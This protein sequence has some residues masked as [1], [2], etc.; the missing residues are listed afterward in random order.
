[1]KKLFY[2]C[3]LACSLALLSAVVIVGC[4]NDDNTTGVESLGGSIDTTYL[5]WGKQDPRTWLPKTQ[6]DR[7][8]TYKN[9]GF[10]YS[11]QQ[12][13]FGDLRIPKN[14]K[15]KTAAGYPLIIMVH[16]GAWRSNTTL[17]RVAPLIEALTDEGMATWSIEFS[18]LGNTG[19]GYPGTFRDVGEGV[20][21]VRTL[22]PEWN[23]DLNRV[24]ILGHSSGGQLG[25]WAASRHNLSLSS[26]LYVANPLPVKAVVSLAGIASLEY[27]LVTGGRTD[28]LTF[29]DVPDAASAVPLYPSTSPY[30]MLPIGIPTS[31]IVGTADDPW[32]IAAIHQYV[33]AVTAL[34]GTV[35]LSEP[36]GANEMDIIDP[37]SPSWPTVVREVYWAFGIPA[38]TRDLNYSKFCPMNG[39][40]PPIP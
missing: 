3:L 31:H 12:S 10:L 32:R 22:A 21:Y 5:N 19:G 24:I 23:L 17:D 8:I 25:L 15:L 4:G 13:H 7:R 1:M 2:L 6:P 34:G 30:H 26:P 36:V 40:L 16:G 11:D 20:D 9:S 27:A 33:D 14:N 29:L 35:H 37:C 18:R 39:R 38:P 28:I